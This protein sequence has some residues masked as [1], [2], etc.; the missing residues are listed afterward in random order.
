VNDNYLIIGLTVVGVLACVYVLVKR[1][2]GKTPV[3]VVR[4]A[5]PPQPRYELTTAERADV[6]LDRVVSAALKDKKR[7]QTVNRI[8]D[9][10][11]A[12]LDE[13][14]ERARAQAVEQFANRAVR[15]RSAEYEALFGAPKE[16]PADPKSPPP[17]SPS[18]P[19]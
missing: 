5:T 7:A 15:A 18:A 17:A 10:G 1:R 2:T 16:L 12:L 19:G 13:I 11:R 8:T 3:E 6:D 4:E 9:P 14:D